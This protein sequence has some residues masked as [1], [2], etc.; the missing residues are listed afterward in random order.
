MTTRVLEGVVEVAF[1]DNDTGRCSLKMDDGNWY[2]T[3]KTHYPELKDK[4]I[5]LTLVKKGKYWN[6]AGE[7]EVVA[8]QAPAPVAAGPTASVADNR[9]SSI[10]LQ[11]SYKTGS[12]LAIAMLANDLLTLPAKKA[13]KYDA[14]LALVDEVTLRIYN[15]CINPASFLE[16][17]A[18][19]DDGPAVPDED[20]YDPSDV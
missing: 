16:G 4:R 9:Q 13:A 17:T 14:F 1:K 18:P 11:S 19:A 8:N 20:E 12:E 15:N 6:V 10:V 2:S 5:K 3:F 7:P